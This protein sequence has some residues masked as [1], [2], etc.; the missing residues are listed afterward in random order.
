[1]NKIQTL[2]VK[3]I[4]TERIKPVFA[5]P[6]PSGEIENPSNVTFGFLNYQNASKIVKE[7]SI[8]KSKYTKMINSFSMYK[9]TVSIY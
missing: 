8:K 3:E 4:L 9:N 2:F 1:M 5:F 6:Y 7:G